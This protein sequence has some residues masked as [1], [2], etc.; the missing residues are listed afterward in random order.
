MKL[1]VSRAKLVSQTG[2][3]LPV[4]TPCS[5]TLCLSSVIILKRI[6]CECISPVDVPMTQLDVVYSWVQ[7][8]GLM[9]LQE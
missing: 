3:W 6:H 1:S 7:I 5:V 4:D 8:K 2:S 9:Q